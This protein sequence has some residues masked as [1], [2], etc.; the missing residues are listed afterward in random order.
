MSGMTM[1]LSGTVPLGWLINF[2]DP[3]ARPPAHNTSGT[4]SLSNNSSGDGT[5]PGTPGTL[6]EWLLSVKS[7][8]YA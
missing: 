4:A 6:W 5:G 7:H 2:V 1:C 8:L 3:E